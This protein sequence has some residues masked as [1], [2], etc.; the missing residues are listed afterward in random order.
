[1]GHT[2]AHSPTF[3]QAPKPSLSICATSA[4]TRRD[5]S[6]FPCGREPRCAIFAEVKSI[7]EAF[8]HAATHA[9]QPMHAAAANARSASSFA[10]GTDAASGADPVLTLT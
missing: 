8:G 9:P 5:A 1:M 6:T 4:R 7:A 2:A 3:V 10:T